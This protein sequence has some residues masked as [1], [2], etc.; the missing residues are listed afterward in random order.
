MISL[1]MVLIY[2]ERAEGANEWDLMLTHSFPSPVLALAYEDVLG[3]GANELI[4]NTIAGLHVL[5]VPQELTSLRR[6]W[7]EFRL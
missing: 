2:K 1:Q 7:G 3:D 5:Q 6:K 4:V